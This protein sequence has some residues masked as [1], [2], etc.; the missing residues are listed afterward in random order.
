MPLPETPKHAQASLGQSPAGSLLLSP[1][2]WCT[3]GFVCGLQASVSQS[4]VSSRG[5]MVGLM[6]TSSKR[7]YAIPRSTAPRAPAPS[8]PLL[9]HTS[10]EDN[11]TQ[12]CLSLCGVLGPGVDKVFFEPSEHLWRVWGL[13]LNMILS[14]LPSCRGFSFALGRGVSF[15]G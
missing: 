4:F 7:A 13:I 2:S 1:G 6:E 10:T 15:F 12:F 8:S 11:Q 3:Q 9:T 5:S 14:L